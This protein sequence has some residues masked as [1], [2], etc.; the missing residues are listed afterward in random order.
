VGT[1]G[2]V[3]VVSADVLVVVVAVVVLGF[4]VVVDVFVVGWVVALLVALVVALELVELGALVLPPAPA[5]SP[6][7]LAKVALAFFFCFFLAPAAFL[8]FGRPVGCTVGVV[9]DAWSVVGAAA[10]FAASWSRV[11]D[12]AS[13]V[14]PPTAT[15][16]M[17]ATAPVRVPAT[18]RPRSRSS[19]LTERT[20]TLC[21]ES[22]EE[23]V[24]QSS[25]ES[26]PA[27]NP[28]VNPCI[29]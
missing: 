5:L 21:G 19:G 26:Q 8:A 18:R 3:V 9:V 23:P 4:G 17:A 10:T 28:Q 7:T 29:R 27:R 15:K 22:G 12:A 1:A 20:R 24:I 16:V 25:N 6:V 11:W 14:V 13:A 2:G